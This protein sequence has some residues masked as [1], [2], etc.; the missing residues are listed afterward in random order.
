MRVG[1]IYQ[2][3]PHRVPLPTPPTSEFRV[4]EF[5]EAR[6]LEYFLR[7]ISRAEGALFP[8]I[9]RIMQHGFR[10][11]ISSEGKTMTKEAAKYLNL[12]YW[13]LREI[14]WSGALPMVRLPNKSGGL[15]RRILIDR[16]D[17]DSLIEKSKESF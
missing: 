8:A 3:H 9:C 4:L 10:Q 17:L 7:K 11:F 15:C 16:Q 5:F 2:T 13:T 14:V 1:T 6:F 12:G